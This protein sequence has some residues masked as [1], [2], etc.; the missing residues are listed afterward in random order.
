MNNEK[1]G[2]CHCFHYSFFIIHLSFKLCLAVTHE[3]V[4]A[5]AAAAVVAGAQ[6]HVGFGIVLFGR[7]AVPLDGLG[8]VFGDAGAVEQAVAQEGL[9]PG[10]ALLG[11]LCGPE[12][13]L[14]QVLAH[15][16]AAQQ[17]EGEVVLRL[18]V[19]R[20]GVF[21]VGHDVRGGLLPGGFLRP[22]ARKGQ[23]EGE[24]EGRDVLFHRG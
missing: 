16:G 12:D 20:L 1:S 9:C 6:A 19:A 7:F 21:H 10:E 13:G 14:R 22:D 2:P 24:E 5:F 23:D 8:V 11:G 17:A 18:R 4:G 15:S 3:T